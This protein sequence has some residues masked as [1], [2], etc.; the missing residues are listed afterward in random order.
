MASLKYGDIEVDDINL[1]SIDA[2]N[3]DCFV[4]SY[5]G[6][7]SVNTLKFSK[8]NQLRVE[9]NGN[10]GSIDSVKDVTV[11]GNV[12][13]FIS[14]N[15]IKVQGYIQNIE[16]RSNNVIVNPSSRVIVKSLKCD[17]IVINGDLQFFNVRYFTN[18]TSLD[19]IVNGNCGHVTTHNI[20]K[21]KGNVGKVVANTS[22][23][24]SKC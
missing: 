8:P 19:V 10:V 23:T 3:D 16:C 7:H 11:F 18:D 6:S 15:L 22:V 4:I 5:V 1:I 12:E 14:Y 2:M 17:R 9:I 13:S 21:V 20:G 24:C